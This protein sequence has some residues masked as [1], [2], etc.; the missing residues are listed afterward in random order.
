M[1]SGVQNLNRHKLDRKLD[2]SSKVN[3][4]MVIGLVRL[5]AI[6]CELITREAFSKRKHSDV[7]FHRI[8]GGMQVRDFKV[9]PGIEIREGYHVTVHYESRNLHG[10]LIED[11]LIKYPNGVSF[12]AG[13][14]GLVPPVLYRSVL[15]MRLGG[16]RQ[17]IAPPSMHFPDQFPGQ[18]L[19]YE[20]NVVKAK[21]ITSLV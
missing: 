6:K 14:P 10:R 19:I 1:G 17:V 21:D 8:E 4:P 16:K 9:G 12:I 13:K 7:E 2:F 20:I 5:T 3:P 18:V 15:T 11:S